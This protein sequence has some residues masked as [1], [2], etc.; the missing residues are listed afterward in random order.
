MYCVKCGVK[1]E[2]TEKTCP[3]CGTVAF[4]PDIKRDEVERL[5]PENK[6]PRQQVNKLAALVIITTMFLLPIII[7]LLC[8][9]K[10]NS[11]V[12][13]SGYVIGA[14]IL[15]YVMVVLPFWFRKPNPVIFVPVS[16]AS[17]GGYLWYVNF[18]ADGDWFLSFGFPL[19]GVLGLIA[20]AVVTLFK[21]VKR[22]SL[23]IS[24]GAILLLGILSP[25]FE[26]LVNITFAIEKYSFWSVYPLVASLLLGGMLIFLAINSSVREKLEKKFFI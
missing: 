26:L 9:L 6:Y 14:L 12:G 17:I 20:T 10:V 1:L 18:A 22:G 15:G 21:Y 19:V 24:G 4:H 8:D 3:L 25:V 11:R 13:W 7:T 5:Y 23:Y 16:F 2:D